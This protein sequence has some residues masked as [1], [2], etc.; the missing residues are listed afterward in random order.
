ME[1]PR[2]ILL[3]ED[4]EDQVMLAMRA[5]RKHGIVDEVDKVVVASD[6]EE[7]LDYL[8]GRG[9]Y[10]GR[11]T[12]VTPEF[13]L[14]DVDLPSTTGLGVLEELRADERTELLPVILF[15]ASNR[16]GDVI[17]GYKL[18]ANSYVTK[19]TNFDDFSQAMSHLGWYWLNWNETP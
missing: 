17:E 13:V 11:D 18:G 19:P 14:L 2:E 6:G 7:A 5:M 9:E 12:S 15:S 1:E 3:V 4:D 16:R 10:Q 8:F